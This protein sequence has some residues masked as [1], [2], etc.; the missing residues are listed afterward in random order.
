MIRYN[1]ATTCNE[2]IPC[3]NCGADMITAFGTDTCPEC[4][5]QESSSLH[6]HAQCW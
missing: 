2:T 6:N 5:E 1:T 4:G 3:F